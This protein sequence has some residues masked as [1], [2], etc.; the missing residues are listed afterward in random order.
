VSTSDRASLARGGGER[1]EGRGGG[2]Q[3]GGGGLRYLNNADVVFS[4]SDSPAAIAN[5][6]YAIN[7]DGSSLSPYSYLHCLIDCL[8]LPRERLLAPSPRLLPS[9]CTRLPARLAQ[10]TA[11]GP[12]TASDRSKNLSPSSCPSGTSMSTSEGSPKFDEGYDWRIS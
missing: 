7:D 9:L 11:N 1:G 10:S 4:L 8:S 6:R 3:E 5:T 12:S 2:G